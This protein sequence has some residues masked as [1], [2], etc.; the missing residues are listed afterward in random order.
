[1]LVFRKIL[2]MH[3]RN[4]PLEKLALR[5]ILITALTIIVCK[6]EVIT[7]GFMNGREIFSVS[8]NLPVEL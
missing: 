5:H 2:R 3:Y 7:T 4:N 6:T 8:S 1:M